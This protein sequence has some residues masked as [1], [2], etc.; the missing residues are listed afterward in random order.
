MSFGDRLGD[1]Y[2]LSC[3]IYGIYPDLKLWRQFRS[4]EVS[5]NIS[6][7]KIKDLEVLCHALSQPLTP[8]TIE[9]KSSFNS[10]DSRKSSGH[11]KEI[12]KLLQ[13]LSETLKVSR[14]LFTLKFVNIFVPAAPLTSFS[15]HQSL[16]RTSLLWKHTLRSQHP[17]KEKVSGLT[18]IVLNN[19]PLIGD[20]GL[21]MLATT[22][23]DDLWLKGIELENC[24]ISSASVDI[25]LKLLKQNKCLECLSLQNN[26]FFDRESLLKVEEQLCKESSYKPPSVKSHYSFKTNLL[27]EKTSTIEN[28]K[29]FRKIDLEETLRL[30]ADVPEELKKIRPGIPWRI[31]GRIIE[32][33]ERLPVGTLSSILGEINKP[34]QKETLKKNSEGINLGISIQNIRNVIKFYKSKCKS[35][36]KKRLGAERRMKHLQKKLESYKELYSNSYVVD[37]ETFSHIEQCFY[38]F[39]KFLD[40]LKSV[41][42]QGNE[43]NCKTAYHAA[44]T[45]VDILTY[46]H[47]TLLHCL[48]SAP[49]YYGI[50]GHYSV[51]VDVDEELTEVSLD[52]SSIS[53]TKQKRLGKI[54]SKKQSNSSSE[55]HKS[56]RQVRKPKEKVHIN[57]SEH[58]HKNLSKSKLSASSK[59]GTEESQLNVKRQD[60]NFQKDSDEKSNYKDN[61]YSYEFEASENESSNSTEVN[62]HVIEAAGKDSS[63]RSVSRSSSHK[64]SKQGNSYS[65]T[66]T[67]S[68]RNSSSKTVHESIDEPVSS[69]SDVKSIDKNKGREHYNYDYLQESHSSQHHTDSNSIHSN[70]ESKNGNNGRISSS[71]N[72]SVVNSTKKFNF[73]DHNQASNLEEP[74]RLSNIEFASELKEAFHMVT[75]DD[76]INMNSD[77]LV[78]RNTTT[79][80]MNDGSKPKM[81]NSSYSEE[82]ISSESGSS[83][84]LKKS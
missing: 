24:G 30:R 66:N 73:S 39:Y 75:D 12:R 25:I 42:I 78:K 50:F 76:K 14:T 77:S 65:Q 63:S 72:I 60:E 57:K 82:N 46:L 38:N 68:S 16:N 11:G 15:Q 79:I 35:E 58:R 29:T 71:A 23:A 17:D 83:N 67:T 84:S 26:P 55:T 10:E 3:E 1:Q 2:K 34:K 31:E 80:H 69:H 40:K 59:S 19:N 56:P 64:S 48:L 62:S 33:N 28:R 81:S 51:F 8:V 20:D 27:K 61:S 53:G 22:L 43:L 70:K 37:E 54:N 21:K 32:R 41:G 13:S 74:L 47:L 6:D 4:G 7:L 18:H 49:D 5:L 45:T 36:S 52:M 44:A 9:I